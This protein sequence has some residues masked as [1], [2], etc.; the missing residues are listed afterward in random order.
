MSEDDCFPKMDWLGRLI[1]FLGYELAKP[2][3]DIEEP[4]SAMYRAKREAM[5][6]DKDSQPPVLDLNYVYHE[7]LGMTERV[8][9]LE[10]SKPPQSEKSDAVSSSLA[11][12]PMPRAC[13]ACR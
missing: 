7:I 10:E 9:K 13:K 1:K 5:N 11:K 3:P 6:Q 4:L 8:A 12:S 2:N